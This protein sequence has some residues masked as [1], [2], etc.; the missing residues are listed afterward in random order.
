MGQPELRDLPQ[1]HLIR[2]TTHTHFR[3]STLTIPTTPSSMGAR[4]EMLNH[5]QLHTMATTDMDIV[6]TLTMAMDTTMEERKDPLKPSQ[7]H[8][9]GGM[10]MDMDMDTVTYL[11]MD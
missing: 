1:H 5:L 10:D 4:K 7:I 3:T 2:P 8:T 6:D 9:T 11:I